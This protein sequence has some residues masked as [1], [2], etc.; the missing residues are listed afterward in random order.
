[1]LI[2]CWTPSLNVNPSKAS[3]L[4]QLSKQI[5]LARGTSL[6]LLTQKSP[7]HKTRNN[8]PNWQARQSYR[9]RFQFD[10]WW[11]DSFILPS[12]S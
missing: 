4:L 1:M 2:F 10:F 12:Q 8:S 5:N 7:H 11:F 3:E 9:P 6:S